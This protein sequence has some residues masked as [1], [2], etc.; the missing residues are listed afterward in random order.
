MFAEFTN[1]DQCQ[2][3]QLK[4]HTALGGSYII[5][6]QEKGRKELAMVSQLGLYNKNKTM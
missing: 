2:P 1:F 5:E 4:F 3:I 6:E